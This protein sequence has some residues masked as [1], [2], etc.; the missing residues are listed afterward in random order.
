MVKYTKYINELSTINFNI[1]LIKIVKLLQPWKSKYL[2]IY[3][4]K[5]T[6]INSLVIS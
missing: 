6:L 3:G 2:S 5:M 1:K 4:K